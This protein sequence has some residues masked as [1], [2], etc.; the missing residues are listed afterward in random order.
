MATSKGR[1]GGGN[2]GTTDDEVERKLLERHTQIQRIRFS[3][4][5]C[6]NA[7]A[8]TLGVKIYVRRP[9]ILPH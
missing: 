2:G 5:H 3:V 7:A 6:F 4:T 1:E 8:A 9:W